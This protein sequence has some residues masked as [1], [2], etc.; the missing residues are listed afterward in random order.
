MS[1]DDST[2]EMSL[3]DHLDELRGRVLRSVAV[4]FA[5][6]IISFLYQ[7]ELKTIFEWPFYEA[8][9]LADASILEEL[10]LADQGKVFNVMSL[11]E[12][13]MNAIKV[14]FTAAL[15]L[16]FPFFVY[17]MWGFVAPAL[18]KKE[19]FAGF[20]F[21][22]L[23][24]IFFYSGI[25]IGY[26]FG[27]PWL[28]YLLFELT[29]SSGNVAM[30]IRESEY[31]SFFTVMTVAFGMIMNIP[32]LVM[33][34][35]Y[36]RLVTPD[37]LAARRGYVVMAAVVLAAMLSPPDPFSQIAL[38]IPMWFL[39]EAGLVMSRMLVRRRQ[40]LLGEA[41]GDNSHEE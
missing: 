8:M 4:F 14:S 36:V 26:L 11:Q 13:V 32:W 24:V 10:G 3:G 29:A 25:T 33:V 17:Q 40:R 38:F 5:V 19:R 27:L 22:P 39:F 18:L 12:S 21:V 30:I 20:M 15:A 23:A 37:Q 28:Y 16:S 7:K 9:R 34:M 35:V 1:V 41:A 6:F 2:R 31:L